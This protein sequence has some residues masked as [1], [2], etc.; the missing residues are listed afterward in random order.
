[1]PRCWRWYAVALRKSLTETAVDCFYLLGR[2]HEF[3]FAKFWTQAV[4]SFSVTC[5][6]I[7]FSGGSPHRCQGI[8][9]R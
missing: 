9:L 5:W 2:L 7:S 4:K 1:M 3:N 8:K 6:G